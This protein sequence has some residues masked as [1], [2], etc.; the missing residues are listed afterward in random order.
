MIKIKLNRF[1]I[2]D[3]MCPDNIIRKVKTSIFNFILYF[4]N[5]KWLMGI[6]VSNLLSSVGE[7]Y[8]LNNTQL[9]RLNHKDIM[10]L[11]KTKNLKF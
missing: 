10:R 3:K 4:L 6:T 11:K 7:K 9:L 5:F 1:E 8:S 2:H